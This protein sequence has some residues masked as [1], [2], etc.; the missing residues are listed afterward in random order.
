M[1][2]KHLNEF[3]RNLENFQLSISKIDRLDHNQ[4]I[5]DHIHKLAEN[6]FELNR[7]FR[8]NEI[9]NIPEMIDNLQQRV[10]QE[11]LFVEPKFFSSETKTLFFASFR[12]DFDEQNQS[13]LNVVNQFERFYDE[14][15]RNDQ[16][17]SSSL[18][19]QLKNLQVRRDSNRKTKQIFLFFVK[20]KTKL[21]QNFKRR[22]DK[23]NQRFNRIFSSDSNIDATMKLVFARWTNL[24]E[25]LDREIRRVKLKGFLSSKRLSSVFSWK[26]L[27]Y[28]SAEEFGRSS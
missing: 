8:F 17:I 28:L 19:S 16:E 27:I 25:V 2:R 13:L 15:R 5:F 3:H 22:V 4:I 24:I 11:H 7:D 9:E 1:I 12:T 20:T 18:P 6:L 21:F 23:Q 26:S 14:L 10:F